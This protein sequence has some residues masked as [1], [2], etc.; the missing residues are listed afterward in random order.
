[1]TPRMHRH[2]A[3]FQVIRQI[4]DAV[5]ER[6]S[7]VVE[8]RLKPEELGHVRFRMTAGENSL[9]MTIL[10]D[11]P[12]TLDLLRRH[13]DQLARHLD[14]LGCSGTQ[15][16]FG[17]GTGRGGGSPGVPVGDDRPEATDVL[18]QNDIKES[19][20]GLDIRI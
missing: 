3:A 7:D 1:M 20:T 6:T 11:R 15:F 12:E 4:G 14:D 13:V 19:E 2:E 10:A 17:E 8:L 18:A 16:R 5:L 9:N